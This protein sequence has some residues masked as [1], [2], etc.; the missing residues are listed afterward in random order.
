LEGARARGDRPHRGGRRRPRGGARGDGRQLMATLVR[1][2][3]AL[4]GVTEAAIQTWL[5]QPGEA[6]AVGQPIA[7][8]ETEKAVVEYAAEADGTLG[9]VLVDEGAN[10]AVGTPIAVILAAGERADA[11][12]AVLGEESAAAGGAGGAAAG[13]AADAAAGGAGGA[14]GGAGGAPQPEVAA[15]PAPPEPE[16]APP[17]R[18]EPETP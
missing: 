9:K 18:T 10:V 5:V 3:A 13:G 8:I 11:A 16:T 15:V 14:D 7:E 12:D 2:P 4:A 1:M 17:S 6:V